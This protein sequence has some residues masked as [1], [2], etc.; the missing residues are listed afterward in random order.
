MNHLQIH[1]RS[2]EKILVGYY[3]KA[4]CAAKGIVL[5]NFYRL[6]IFTDH[7]LTGRGFFYLGD[8]RRLFGQNLI[9]K[10]RIKSS[11]PF[12]SRG[13]LFQCGNRHAQLAT[14]NLC[15]FFIKDIFQDIWSIGH[16]VF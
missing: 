7:A 3:R 16:G 5:G 4:G 15:G 10:G 11:R 13:N 14:G 6:K 1:F 12:H 2:L 9:L 8:D